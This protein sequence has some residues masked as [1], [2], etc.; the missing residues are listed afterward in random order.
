[1]AATRCEV[2]AKYKKK[3]TTYDEYPIRFFTSANQNNTTKVAFCFVNHEV[4]CFSVLPLQRPQDV[5]QQR[6]HLNLSLLNLA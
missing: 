4:T 3:A 1:V 5:N 6:L 2:S